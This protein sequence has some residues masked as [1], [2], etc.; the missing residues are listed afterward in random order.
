MTRLVGAGGKP[1]SFPLGMV[2]LK[3][4]PG[5]GLRNSLGRTSG[6]CTRRGC[7]HYR[8]FALDVGIHRGLV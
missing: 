3:A 8:V 1:G 5:F 6:L 7:V 2:G 4:G